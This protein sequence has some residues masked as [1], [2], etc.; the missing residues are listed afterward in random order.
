[1]RASVFHRNETNCQHSIQPPVAAR[2]LKYLNHLST[3]G[4]CSSE[5]LSRTR[6]ALLRRSKGRVWHSI[7]PPT[8]LLF[9]EKISILNLVIVLQVLLWAASLHAKLR[10]CRACHHAPICFHAVPF[11]QFFHRKTKKYFCHNLRQARCCFGCCNLQLVAFVASYS[12]ITTRARNLAW[13]VDV[14]SSITYLLYSILNTI[15]SQSSLILCSLSRQLDLTVCPLFCVC[16]CAGNTRVYR[17]GITPE[18]ASMLAVL[19]PM[20][21]LNGEP[22][23]YGE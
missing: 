8:I 15:I 21:L 22:M 20:P 7:S 11:F 10:A 12:G 23:M 18:A 1:M 13:H 3:I 19:P 16:E 6:I 2:I 14:L 9:G 5:A 4:F 17:L